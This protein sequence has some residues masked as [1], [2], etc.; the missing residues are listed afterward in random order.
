MLCCYHSPRQWTPLAHWKLREFNEMPHFFQRRLAA[1][2]EP[3]QMY[4]SQF[5]STMAAVIA[6]AM[7]YIAGSVVSMLTLLLLHAI[8]ISK[9]TKLDASAPYFLLGGFHSM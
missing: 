8:S 1:S 3:A 2:Y 9:C 7:A 6:Q 4:I 5:P